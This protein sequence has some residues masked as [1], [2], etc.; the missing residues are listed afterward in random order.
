MN[1]R[2]AADLNE[3]VYAETV[4]AEALDFL[5]EVRHGDVSDKELDNLAATLRDALKARA[6]ATDTLA[7]AISDASSN[8]VDGRLS[9]AE[10]A[11]LVL[12]M[13][14]H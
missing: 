7:N 1:A 3:L 10:H 13:A 8:R 14:G 4:V 5:A 2:I 9:G 11:D 12:K 6:E